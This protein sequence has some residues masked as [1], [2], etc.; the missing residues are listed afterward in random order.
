M[1]ESMEIFLES[2]END[3]DSNYDL[4]KCVFGAVFHTLHAQNAFGSVLP[5]SGVIGY[6]YI[7]RTD[8][9]T[10]SAANT[11]IFVAFNAEQRKITHGF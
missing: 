9:F 4:S 7:H 8:P 6:I 10:F 1:P 5:F 2:V 3:A 11:F